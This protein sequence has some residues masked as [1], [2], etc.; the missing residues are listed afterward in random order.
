MIFSMTVTAVN[1]A[2]NDTTA[3]DYSAELRRLRD[4]LHRRG[5]DSE[6]LFTSDRFEIYEDIDSFFKNSAERK[7][8][9]P[10]NKA[11]K[12][13]GK[14]EAARVFEEEL[15]RYKERI[16]FET[17]KEYLDEFLEKY[18]AELA[19]SEAKYGIPK[20]LTASV[21]GLESLF[22]RTLGRHLAFNVYVSMYVKGYKVKWATEQLDEL[23][24][25]ARK[26]K[27]D[28]FVFNS[29][30]AG[31][32]GPMQFLPWSLNRWFVGDDVTNMEDCIMSA[33]YFLS[34]HKK[35][36]GSIE[37]AVNSYNPSRLYVQTVLDLAD[38][39]KETA[40]KVPAAGN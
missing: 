24:R 13:K 8:I 34:D 40:S 39:A 33:A 3:A 31:A 17:K 38:Y 28:V 37:R 7:G 12:E 9:R 20:E 5:Y 26:K 23:L 6:S 14:A 2:G 22:G 30:Y 36:R 1:A 25:F 19:A 29:S 32:I 10:V 11:R 4:Y 15:A 27:R 18:A 35:K 21:I 16:G